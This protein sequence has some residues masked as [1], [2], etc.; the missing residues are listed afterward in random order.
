MNRD[1][2]TLQRR[3][4]APDSWLW[5]L[6]SDQ[7]KVAVTLIG[8]ANWKPGKTFSGGK[9]VQVDRGQ[10]MTSL[11][12][13]AAAS[14]VSKQTVRTTLR[15]LEKAEFLTRTSTSRFTL[16]TILN[17]SREQNRPKAEQHAQQ[18]TIN[19]P[20]THHQH[21]A[22]TPLTPIEPRNQE[23]T[24][25]GN[26]RETRARGLDAFRQIAI[27]VWSEQEQLRAELRAEGISPESRSLGLTP[28]VELI[29]RISERVAFHAETLD[30]EAARQA[31][32]A[33]CRHVLNV[34]VTEARAQRTLRWLSGNHW[35]EDRFR[36]QLVRS[37][38]EKAFTAKTQSMTAAEILAFDT[39]SGNP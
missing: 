39:G 13:I 7:T 38:G 8:M 32:A 17:Y 35:R 30:D 29:H 16:I 22:N 33:D 9:M 10:V 25:P 4:F 26:Q 24:Q 36:A 28:D 18:H 27:E 19:T 11:D 1:F 3:I 6:P 5:D 20:L 15:N 37:P 31:A 21:A 12:A 34:L 14:R 2:F 23:T